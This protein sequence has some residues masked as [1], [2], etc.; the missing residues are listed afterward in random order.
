[1]TETDRKKLD[2]IADDLMDSIL[3]FSRRVAK[4]SAHPGGRKFD[5]SRFVL[6]KVQETGPISMSEIG[7]HMEISKPYMT[8]LVDKLIS[9]GL[10]ERI[11]DPDDRRV[12]KIRITAAGR[13]VI[14]EF[15]KAAREAVITRLS[16]L[17]SEDISSLHESTKKMRSILARLEQD[18]AREPGHGGM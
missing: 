16:S 14:R 8:A 5:P 11:T 3:I 12:V 18:R 15:T 7:R 10:V 9:E 1:M 13:N 2:E 17:S 6:R 4:E